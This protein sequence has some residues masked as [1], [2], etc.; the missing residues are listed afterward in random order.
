MFMSS[1][2]AV[3]SVLQVASHPECILQVTVV[4]SGWVQV[5]GVA[6]VPYFSV[7]ALTPVDNTAM[8]MGL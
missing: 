8:E 5:L 3:Q 2:N 1:C 4:G 6:V 7:V